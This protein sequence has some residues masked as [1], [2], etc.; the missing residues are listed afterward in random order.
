MASNKRKYR[1][2]EIE[3]L[4]CR[5]FQD[6]RILELSI[7]G[8]FIACE[9]PLPKGST[10]NLEVAL[11]GERTIR[12]PSRV[13]R[14][15]DFYE[16]THAE[17]ANGMG[18]S[19]ITIEAEDRIAITRYLASVHGSASTFARVRSSLPARLR[20]GETWSP[21]VVR[22]MGERTLFIATDAVLGIGD[23][24]HLLLGL[25]NARMPVEAR[26]IVLE[27]TASENGDGAGLEV[28]ISEVGSHARA[29][30]DAY[31]KDAR[32]EAAVDRDE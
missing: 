21:G 13:Q 18:L 15:G 27:L 10:I 16:G 7:G 23:E 28:E 22:Q 14:V 12:V 26:G 2:L 31:L 8:A 24:V 30:I 6:G 17:P 1:R 29:L 9:R 19:F 5:V 20:T 3:R 25:P 32:D 11:P 4:P